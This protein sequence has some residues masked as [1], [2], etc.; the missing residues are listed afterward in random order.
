MKIEK[1]ERKEK[2][3]PGY[4]V[5]IIILAIAEAGLA[6]LLAYYA[7]VLQDT[8]M[9]GW[10]LFSALILLALIFW[11]LEKGYLSYE[12]VYAVE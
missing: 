2:D 3:S 8:K 4:Q 11:A 7:V 12:R 6:A 5:L 1:I 10:L 9:V